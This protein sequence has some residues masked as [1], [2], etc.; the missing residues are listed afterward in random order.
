M[1]TIATTPSGP[2]RS[3]WFFGPNRRERRHGH[4]PTYDD[5]LMAYAGVP[6]RAGAGFRGALSLLGPPFGRAAVRY[7]RFLR[8]MESRRFAVALAAPGTRT[9]QITVPK[10]RARSHHRR[11][12]SRDGPASGQ[13]SDDPPLVGAP[14]VRRRRSSDS[15]AT[16]QRGFRS[17]QTEL[18]ELSMAA[19]AELLGLSR[20]YGSQPAIGCLLRPGLRANRPEDRRRSARP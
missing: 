8:Q 4:D 14:V 17:S 13:A 1:A 10:Q 20:A 18:G 6:S 11:S 3:R 5:P 12:S 16:E 2:A 9:D 15:A 19:R 7:G